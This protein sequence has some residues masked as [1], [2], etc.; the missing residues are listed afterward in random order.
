VD[1][2]EQHFLLYCRKHEN[3]KKFLSHLIL[4]KHIAKEHRKNYPNKINSE[5]VKPV[6]S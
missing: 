5:P 6:K 4:F 1:E 2:D 3:L